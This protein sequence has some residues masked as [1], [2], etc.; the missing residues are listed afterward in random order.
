MKKLA[1]LGLVIAASGAFA[2]NVLNVTM[3]GQPLVYTDAGKPT[4]C[5]IRVLGIVDPVARQREFRSFDISANMYGTGIALGKV[6]GEIQSLASPDPHSGRRQVLHGAWFRSEGDD[7][8]TPV[9]NS[10]RPSSGDKGAY[11]F[12]ASV[13]SATDFMLAVIKRKPIQ[14]GI[15]WEKD[16]EAIYAGAVE[17]S[18][19]ERQ[20]V[21]SCI[22]Q[23]FK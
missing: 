11:L 13:S 21:L 12:Q 2:Q 19:D 18:E 14:V 8:V 10:F 17:L 1:V 9:G 23:T 20:Q 6:I 15:R 16:K 3:R 22:E 7:P 4:G 5:G